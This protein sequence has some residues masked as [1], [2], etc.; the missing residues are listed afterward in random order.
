MTAINAASNPFHV[1][2]RHWF[3]WV[4]RSAVIIMGS[5]GA[6]KTDLWRKMTGQKTPERMS[7]APDE[8]YYFPARRGALALTTVP[9]QESSNRYQALDSIFNKFT[10]IRGIIFVAHFGFE[11]IWPEEL[12]I[13]SAETHGLIDLRQRAVDRELASFKATCEMIRKK[14]AYS[15]AKAPKW[16]LVLANKADLYWADINLARDYYTS[17]CGSDFDLVARNLTKG[18]G[19]LQSL[20]YHVVPAAI[21]D[22]EYRFSSGAWAAHVPSQLAELQCEASLAAIA[23]ILRDLH[24]NFS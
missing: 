14:Y 24:V 15:P 5:T 19:T 7:I 10:D 6:G 2:K 12:A 1:D 3:P 21:R 23:T 8:G 9:G 4:S 11:T 20:A 22:A 18:L 13:A 16:L 17:G